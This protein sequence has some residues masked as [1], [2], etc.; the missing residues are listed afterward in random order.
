MSELKDHFAKLVAHLEW[1][2]QRVLAA[3]RAAPHA[4]AKALELY[5]HILGSEHVWVSRLYG[6]PP[7]LAVWP[8]LGLD[9]C[10]GVAA[11]NSGQL[12]KIVEAITGDALQRGITY[13]NSAG[14]Q[15]TST[16]EDILTHVMMHGSYHRGQV[17]SLIRA[18]GDTPSPTDYIF[19]ARG[20]P[21]ATRQG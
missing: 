16:L 11:E 13:R 7:R 12:K 17:A 15:F 3:L 6:M 4:P 14:D 2:D 1:A 19:F 18:A 10:E 9:E 5:A 20:A 8:N 21:A